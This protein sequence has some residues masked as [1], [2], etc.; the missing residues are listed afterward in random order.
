MI[1]SVCFLF[2]ALSLGF[3]P[4][5]QSQPLQKVVVTY[6]SRSIA[7]I[8]L[9]IAQERGFFREEGLDPDALDEKNRTRRADGDFPIVWARQYGKGRVY[10]VGWGHPEST[11]DDPRFQRMM[12]EGIKWALG[13]TSADV[14][15]RLFPGR[16]KEVKR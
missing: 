4:I 8:D 13:M 1:K 3:P 9:F 7:S 5:A 12:L 11:W 16:S 14:T 6:S 15:P 2:L 10:N